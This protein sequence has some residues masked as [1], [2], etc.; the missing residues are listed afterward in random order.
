MKT[1]LIDSNGLMCRYFFGIPEM[2]DENGNNVNAVWGFLKFLHKIIT[3]NKNKNYSIVAVFDK[4][5]NNFRKKI[6]PTYKANRPK[7]DSNL[8]YQLNFVTDI[9]SKLNIAMDYHS[10]FEADDLIGS[11]VKKNPNHEKIIFTSDKDLS[12]LLQYPNTRMYNPF[13]SEEITA[14]FIYKKFGVSPEQIPLFLALCGD[15]ADNIPGIEGVG[16]KRAAQIIN[17]GMSIGEFPEKYPKYDFSNLDQM[18][19]LTQLNLQCEVKEITPTNIDISTFNNISRSLN[20]N[21]FI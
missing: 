5:Y 11:Y 17:S 15:S 18:I 9:C 10:D 20:F 8:I 7:T 2:F 4:C 14:D 12:Q 16:V 3:Q 13:S 6:L 1:L 19:S 21:I